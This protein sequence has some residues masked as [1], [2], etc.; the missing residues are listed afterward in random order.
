[1]PEMNYEVVVE[2]LSKRFGSFVA[3]DQ[4]SLEIPRGEVF[5]FLGPNGAGKSIIPCVGGF[6]CP[7]A[8]DQDRPLAC[9]GNL[10]HADEP[11][12][13]HIMGRALVVKIQADLAAGDGLRLG[14]KLVEMGEVSFVDLRRVVRVDAGGG[15][16]ARQVFCVFAPGI[17]LAADFESAAHFRRSF[18][19]AD[20][21][22][23]ADAGLPGAGQHGLEV[24]G[25]A[26]TVK[27]SV[28]IDE[29]ERGP[30]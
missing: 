18:T 5:G 14:E 19:D 21:Q 29:Q 30:R 22:D 28:R 1:M 24:A 17:E 20:G 3:V 4:L 7:A 9:G 11:G 8:V 12:A 27:M 2:S 6:V 13:L 15:V 23:G 16:K 25:V 10:E 26:R